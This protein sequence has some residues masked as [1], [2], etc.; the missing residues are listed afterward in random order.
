M[1]KRKPTLRITRGLP[2]SGKT[3]YARKWVA[4]DPRTRARVNRDDI[5]VQLHGERFYHDRDLMQDTEKAITIA[6]HAAIGQLLQRG[7][8]VI[9]DDTN[10]P[11][12]TA[13]DLRAIAV[14]NGADFE[15]H[16]ML[17]VPLDTVYAQN[18]DRVGT[19]AFVPEHKIAEMAK[20]HTGRNA[21]EIPLA[22]EESDAGF[23]E[24]YVTVP[25]TPDAIMVDIDGTVALMQGR[26]PFDETRVHED[27]PNEAVIRAVR[28]MHAAGN[29]VIFCSGRTDGCY[30]ATEAWLQE[31]VG[32]PYEGLF[33][34]K[35]GD[36][37]KDSIVKVEIFDERIRRFY[38]IVGVFDDRAQVVAAW[39]KLGLP[40]FAVAEG[41]F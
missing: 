28:A 30:D 5:G 12:R 40:V 7:W 14:R 17:D 32:V 20:R 10:L 22:D 8:D 21:Y 38:N 13:R 24:P 25:G 33:M 34:R 1:T 18:L 2:G 9:C 6:Q 37:R 27:R 41:D 36:Q 29:R 11:G 19:P 3:T 39:R 26:S 4:E 15:I 31:H 23:M 16:D 35:S